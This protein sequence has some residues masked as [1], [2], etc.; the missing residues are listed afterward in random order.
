MTHFYGQD[1]PLK[2]FTLLR[3]LIGCL[4][5]GIDKKKFWSQVIPSQV[6]SFR[7]MEDK[8]IH[9]YLIYY[10]VKF[11]MGVTDQNIFAYQSN[12]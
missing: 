4:S 5:E 11:G 7:K 3:R 2:R 9:E 10:L 12:K 1:T 8:E 6:I